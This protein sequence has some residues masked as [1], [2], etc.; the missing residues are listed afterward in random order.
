MQ[1]VAKRAVYGVEFDEW[2]LG[3]RMWGVRVDRFKTQS[4]KV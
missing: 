4:L 3:L 1:G 2:G